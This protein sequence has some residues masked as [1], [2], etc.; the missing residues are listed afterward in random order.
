MSD[1]MIQLELP[2]PNKMTAIRA[3]NLI[4]GFEEGSEQDLINAY[5]FLIDTGLVWSLQGRYG[6]TALRLIDQGLC[7]P[8]SLPYSC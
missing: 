2:F 5:Q 3:T 4:D 1:K 6:R 7:E 8:S